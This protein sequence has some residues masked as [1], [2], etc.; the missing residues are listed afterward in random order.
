MELREKIKIHTDKM[1]E[2]L[3]FVLQE[4]LN[5]YNQINIFTRV[6]ELTDKPWREIS[7]K[8]NFIEKY[9]FEELKK[10]RFN[11]QQ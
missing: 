11:V 10:T 8:K 3:I 4:D 9:G 7:Y 5:L 2:S 1:L 6:F